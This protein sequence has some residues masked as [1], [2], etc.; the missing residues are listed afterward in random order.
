M[1]IPVGRICDATLLKPK[2]LFT[3][4]LEMFPADLE[5]E[6]K[7]RNEDIQDLQPVIAFC[8][9]RTN[10]LRSNALPTPKRK[11]AKPVCSLGSQ[12]SGDHDADSDDHRPATKADL[13]AMIASVQTRPPKKAAARPGDCPTHNA[14]C[15]PKCRRR[16]KRRFRH[17]GRGV[18]CGH[19]QGLRGLAGFLVIAGHIRRGER[20]ARAPGKLGTGG[21]GG[22]GARQCSS[23]R[24]PKRCS[25]I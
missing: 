5:E 3:M 13:E 19:H 6:I 14:D 12:Y 23:F 15:A 21:G 11:T 24:C 1:E 7:T 25:R 16:P 8:K 22:R 2:Q 9:K 4:V 10:K 20:A 17:R 18:E